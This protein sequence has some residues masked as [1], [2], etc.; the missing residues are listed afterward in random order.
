VIEAESHFCCAEQAAKMLGAKS[1][2]AM[3]AKQKAGIGG[4]PK[5]LNTRNLKMQLL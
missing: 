3:Q 1:T 5:H 2:T 4:T